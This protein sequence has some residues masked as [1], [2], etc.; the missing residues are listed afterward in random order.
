MMTNMCFLLL[1]L[2]LVIILYLMLLQFAFFYEKLQE[3]V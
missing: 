2:L 3:A 1:N